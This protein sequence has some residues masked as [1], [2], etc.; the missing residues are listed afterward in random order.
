MSVSAIIH[1]GARELIEYRPIS[2]NVQYYVIV[3]W[4][5]L[6]YA[7]LQLNNRLESYTEVRTA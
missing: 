7:A 6:E 5:Y 3:A 4:F 1:P 2:R